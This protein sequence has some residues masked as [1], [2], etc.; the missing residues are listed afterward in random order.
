MQQIRPGQLANWLATLPT[1]AG[2][3]ADAGFHAPG[4]HE[5]HPAQV[6]AK[7]AEAPVLL[8]VREPWEAALCQ[9]PGS[10]HIPM[11]EIPSRI[12]ELVHAGKPIVCY[13]HH[14]MRSMQVAMFLEH[15]GVSDVYNLVGGIDAWSRE[16][17][18]SC[19]TY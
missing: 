11:R 18:P 12:G 13:C 14:G 2:L 19:P 4:A 5:H 15:H 1:A 9:L 17:D 16:Q 3:Q 8:D 10:L 6:R 7:P